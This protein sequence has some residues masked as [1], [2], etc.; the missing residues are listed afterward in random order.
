MSHKGRG[1]SADSPDSLSNASESVLRRPGVGQ[2]FD[3][4]RKR[5]RRLILLLVNDGA[6]ETEAD[7]IFRGGADS[8]IA[9][10]ELKHNHLPK[11]A[12]AG[13]IEWDRETGRISKGPNFDEIEPL[14]ELLENH[15]DELPP[16]WP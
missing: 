4:L 6:I 5:H 14:L 16:D 15:A 12:D 2:M 9:E 8:E 10:I 13:Y 11:L 7:V 3:L 1:K